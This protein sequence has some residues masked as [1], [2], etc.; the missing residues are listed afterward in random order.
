MEAAYGVFC[1]DI[2]D[3]VPAGTMITFR[4]NE[5]DHH[6]VGVTEGEHLLL[7]AGARFVGVDAQLPESRLPPADRGSR[8]AECR[9]SSHAG[10]L[11]SLWHTRPRKEGQ[12]ARW[13]ALLVAVIQVIGVRCVEVDCL[14]DQSQSERPC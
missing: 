10:T 6:A 3:P 11:A 2:G 8:H 4:G 7:V 5:I 9:C 1:W 12:Q 13:A 14:L